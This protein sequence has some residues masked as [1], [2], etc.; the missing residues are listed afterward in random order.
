MGTNKALFTIQVLVRKFIYPQKGL[1]ICF[2]EFEKDFDKVSHT[3][4]I[5]LV[6]NLRMNQKN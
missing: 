3:E 6:N 4:L 1:Y 2:V 5:N